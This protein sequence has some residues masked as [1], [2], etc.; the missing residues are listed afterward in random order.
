MKD[1]GK[2]P[3]AIDYR[4]AKSADGWKVFDVVVEDLS[5]VINYRGTFAS[6]VSRSG[7]DGLIKVLDEKNR[8]LAKS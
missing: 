4:M 1:P 7:I 2:Q 8:A 5:L 6:E 3:I